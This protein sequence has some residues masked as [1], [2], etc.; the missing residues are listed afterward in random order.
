MPS[1]PPLTL[2][3]ASNILERLLQSLPGWK[4]V[5]TNPKTPPYTA[6]Q[7]PA[8]LETLGITFHDQTRVGR[9]LLWQLAYSDNFLFSKEEELVSGETGLRIRW[10]DEKKLERNGEAYYEFGAV[11]E[12]PD[13]TCIFITVWSRK[14]V[15]TKIKE[16]LKQNHWLCLV[17]RRY[18]PIISGAQLKSLIDRS[19]WLS[20]GMI[21]ALET[22]SEVDARNCAHHFADFS[23]KIYRN[24]KDW[25]D[26][27]AMVDYIIRK[28]P[29]DDWIDE[30]IDNFYELIGQPGDAGKMNSP[31]LI[32]AICDRK[33]A[34]QQWERRQEQERLEAD[35]YKRGDHLS[36]KTYKLLSAISAYF[37]ADENSWLDPPRGEIGHLLSDLQSATVFTED[38]ASRLGSLFTVYFPELD[39][40]IRISIMLETDKRTG[41]TRQTV[42]SPRYTLIRPSCSNSPER[43][44]FSALCADVYPRK[45]SS[46][47]SLR[48]LLV[49]FLVE[50]EVEIS[51]EAEKWVLNPGEENP[52]ESSE[53]FDSFDTGFFTIEP[54]LRT[55]MTERDEPDHYHY[56]EYW[57]ANSIFLTHDQDPKDKD[58]RE[59]I[60]SMTVEQHEKALLMSD[61][62]EAIVAVS[63]L[64]AGR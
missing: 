6:L 31:Q 27:L 58:L 14:S 33:Q 25:S 55:V 13:F 19:N 53:S 2:T 16:V 9:D 3:R 28:A 18:E 11:A 24:K 52:F 62:D 34:A 7:G 47:E 57:M 59:K 38:H 45:S 51:D 5:T 1:V 35:A 4:L 56:T 46:E 43:P 64:A 17:E 36:W 30:E 40:E 15:A 26:L 10:K 32:S 21:K 29:L 39:N 54:C 61:D 50:F 63:A 42:V 44:V 23:R 8:E 49:T 22:C 41:E 60:V 37:D 48:S 12:G 20:K